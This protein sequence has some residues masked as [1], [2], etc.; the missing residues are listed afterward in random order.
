MSRPR[1]VAVMP[2][3]DKLSV[4]LETSTWRP[5]SDVAA[6]ILARVSRSGR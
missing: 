6:E 3:S 1:R 2:K 4:V 5:V